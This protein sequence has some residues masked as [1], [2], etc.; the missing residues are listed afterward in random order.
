VL[1]FVHRRNA[2]C[3]ALEVRALARAQWVPLEE[4]YD[5]LQ[6]VRS[7]SN[8]ISVHHVPMVVGTVVWHNLPDSK[9]SL[10]LMQAPNTPGS[11]RHHKL[12][13][14]L[15]AGLVAFASEAIMLPDRT[16]REASFSVHKTN[17]PA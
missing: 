10:Q 5:S 11:L 13:L 1:A 12:V 6:Q 16:Q 4:W 8:H 2:L 9:E 17:N 7:L 15:N 3:E 14:Y